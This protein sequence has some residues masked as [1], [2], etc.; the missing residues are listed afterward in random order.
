MINGTNWHCHPYYESLKVGVH[1]SP[2]FIMIDVRIK[3]FSNL[4]CPNKQWNQLRPN[5]PCPK[6]HPK[7][8][9]P[10]IW[11]HQTKPWTIA[12][13]SHSKTFQVTT[14]R[15]GSSEKGRAT[16]GGRWRVAGAS[17]VG[18][19]HTGREARNRRAVAAFF[20]LAQ[21]PKDHWW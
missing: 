10:S 3:G 16:H 13:S 1:Q 8:G 4:R 12:I 17:L 11:F 2:S 15:C 20:R 18:W 21:R 19:S 6:F 5:F 9:R 7:Q 14:L